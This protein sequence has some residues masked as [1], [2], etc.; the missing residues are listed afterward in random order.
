MKQLLISLGGAA[1]GG[2]LGYFGF[3][4]LVTQGFYGLIL[5]GGLLGL[6]ASFGKPRTIWVPIASSIAALALGLFAEWREFPFVK[7]ESFGYF[8]RH[9]T[10]LKAVTLLMLAA[11]TALAFWMPY[12]NVEERS[13]PGRN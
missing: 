10:E 2:T 9:V 13:D 7:D 5:P 8:L 12:R 4:W 11:G 3:H 1:I 6:G